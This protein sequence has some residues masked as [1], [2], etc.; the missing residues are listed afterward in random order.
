MCSEQYVLTLNVQV[1]HAANLVPSFL[2]GSN[3][4]YMTAQAQQYGHS[5]TEA[6]PFLY[7]IFV[8]HQKVVP[9]ST[10]H[11]KVMLQ[12]QKQIISL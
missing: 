4:Q 8:F 6:T 11:Q 1:H 9:I 12:Y 5:W 2:V 3:L 7:A 10:V